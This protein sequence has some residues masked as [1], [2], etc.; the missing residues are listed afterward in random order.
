MQ[1]AAGSL[2]DVEAKIAAVMRNMQ[3]L[4]EKLNRRGLTKAKR[5]LYEYQLA[6]SRK[7]LGRL[8]ARSSAPN[9]EAA[10]VLPQKRGRIK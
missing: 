6:E 5:E 8:E 3:A 7:A 10:A 2:D 4:I 1:I 9:W